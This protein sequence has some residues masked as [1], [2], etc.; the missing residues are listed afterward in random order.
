MNIEFKFANEKQR[1]FYY[2]TARNQCISG[3]F[4]NGKS[5]GAALKAATLLFTFSNYRMVVARQVRSDLMKTTYQTFLKVIPHDLIARN[6]EQEG[7]TIF[8][9]GSTIFWLHLDK[10]DE[11]TLRGLEVN[12]IF[13]DQAEEIDEKVYDVLDA[14]VGRW[15]NAII[16]N[17]LLARNN[18]WPQN[19]LTGKYIA[20]SYMM[21]ACNPDT[22][23]HFIYRK[24]H[25]LSVERR[26]NYF[27]TE[28]EW[29]PAL[30]SSETYEQAL[31]HDDEWVAK[32]VKGQWGV[33]SS[34]IHRLPDASLLNYSPELLARI[35]SKG[36]LFRI[37]DHGETSPTC[38]LWAAAIGGV[39]IFFREYYVPN[40]IISYHR[41]SINEMSEYEG[42]SRKQLE[43]YSANYADPSIFHKESQKNAGF[44]SVSREYLDKSLEGPPIAWM[45]ADNN[46]FATRNRINELLRGNFKH[47]ITG[48]TG[49]PGIY[50]I[51]KS[52]DYEFG[53][54][55][56][57]KQIQSQRKKLIGYIDG[58]AIYS[59][60]R[61]D[62]ITDHAYDPIRYFIAMHG[63][64]LSLPRPTPK[65][66]TFDYYTA[67]KKTVK[68]MKSAFQLQS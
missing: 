12:S 8:K 22:Q 32:Y 20:P 65:R 68:K 51:K 7:F 56:S 10:V 64:G 24:Y 38:C 53:C 33:S 52:P 41:K 27:Y 49:S 39:F 3:G 25:P 61:E 43:S 17:E 23:F 9:N 35:R 5:F 30:G 45:P 63:S 31:L 40:Q 34:Q 44:W 48:E 47:P 57:I 50:F 58:K 29:D 66:N 36:N 16:P 59:D 2:A 21:L 1:E 26:T 14:R 60:E 28:C 37:M 18:Q 11:S 62:S 13:V 55:E 54:F 15:D 6:N 19:K 67:A 4:N 46:E 42:E